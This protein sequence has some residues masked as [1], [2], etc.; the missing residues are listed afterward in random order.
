MHNSFDFSLGK[1]VAE[2]LTLSVTALNLGN[3]RF[4][5]DNSATFGGTHYAEQRQ[6]YLEVRYR[7]RF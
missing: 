3:R 7:F 4:L 2:S 5:L 6:I 1:A